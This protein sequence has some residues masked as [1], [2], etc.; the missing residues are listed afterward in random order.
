MMVKGPAIQC[1]GSFP[2]VEYVQYGFFAF[3]ENTHS[4]EA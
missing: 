1:K 4:P 2:R 3:Q